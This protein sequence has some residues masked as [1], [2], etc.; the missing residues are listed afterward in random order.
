MWRDLQGLF[1]LEQRGFLMQ[2]CVGQ[3]FI[4]VLI[5]PMINLSELICLYKWNYSSFMLPI[6]HSILYDTFPYFIDT[7]PFSYFIRHSQHKCAS[8]LFFLKQNCL[9]CSPYN[10]LPYLSI[11]NLNLP[12]WN[13][14]FP[15]EFHFPWLYCLIC[16]WNRL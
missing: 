11:I 5:I 1:T 3:V 15:N 12:R 7:I 2:N 6:P 9:W 10:F 16:F 14:R 13:L 4:L 8:I